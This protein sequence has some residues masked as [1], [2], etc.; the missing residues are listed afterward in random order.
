MSN[1]Y[2]PL[3][4]IAITTFGI[5]SIFLGLFDE[6]VLGIM[7]CA[8]ADIDL[9]GGVPQ[10]GPASF[11]K[12]M[13]EIFDDDARKEIYGDDKADDKPKDQKD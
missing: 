2:G 4:I 1:P 13:S 9:H 11:Q 6:A 12:T 5:V 7:T 3:I 10:W 8:S